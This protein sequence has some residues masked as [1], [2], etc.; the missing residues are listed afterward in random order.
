MYRFGLLRAQGPPSRSP[1]L[2]RTLWSGHP[3]EAELSYETLILSASTDWEQWLYNAHGAD[4]SG[5]NV[6]IPHKIDVF[7]RIPDRTNDAQQIGATNCIVRTPSGWQCHNTDA[8]GFWEGWTSNWN[9]YRPRHQ[10]AWLL[11]NGG[12]ARAIAFALKSQG[13]EVLCFARTPKSNFMDLSQLPFS[14]TEDAPDPDLIVNATSMGHGTQSDVIPPI[15][16]RPL[17]G[18]WAVDAVYGPQPTPFQITASQHDAFVLDGM[19]MLRMQAKKA[20]EYWSGMLKI[21]DF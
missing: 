15:A 8:E 10:R 5:F 21:S 13:F 7:D 2:Y 16:W 12:A 1:E 18:A 20:W 9:G 11:G 3:K 4:W 19:P 6:T 14:A 17:K